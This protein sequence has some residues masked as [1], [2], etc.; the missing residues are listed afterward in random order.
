MAVDSFCTDTLDLLPDAVVWFDK[1]ANLVEVNQT[2]LDM[3]GYTKEE[4]KGLTIFDVNPTMTKEIWP[5][6]WKDKVH[7]EEHYLRLKN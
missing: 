5:A 4:V 6:H 1:D 2:A 3:W 7:C